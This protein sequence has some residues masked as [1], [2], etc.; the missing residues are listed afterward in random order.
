M[1]RLNTTSQI[2][3][4]YNNNIF[5]EEWSENVRMSWLSLRV[6]SRH[7]HGSNWS[8]KSLILAEMFCHYNYL[9]V[10]LGSLHSLPFTFTHW[11]ELMLLLSLQWRTCFRTLLQT[12]TNFLPSQLFGLDQSRY[13]SLNFS[14]SMWSSWQRQTN[15]RP[16]H[17]NG[18]TELLERPRPVEKGFARVF[19]RGPRAIRL[20]APK[21]ILCILLFVFNFPRRKCLGPWSH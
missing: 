8:D 9:T 5:I 17:L 18:S 14:S 19:T 20:G 6:E 10:D 12:A 4:Q 7:S 1:D 21:C 2:Q 16:T 3:Q 15:K 11:I 13:M